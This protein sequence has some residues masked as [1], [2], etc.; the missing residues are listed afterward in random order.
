MMLLL[1]SQSV[2]VQLPVPPCEDQSYPGRQAQ[3][4]P[5]EGNPLELAI[6]LQGVQT[7][8][9]VANRMGS[10]ISQ[11]FVAGLNSLPAGQVLEIQ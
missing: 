4:Y 1:L 7:V 9:T 5:L 10:Q 3:E 6:V 11:S 8:P 2:A